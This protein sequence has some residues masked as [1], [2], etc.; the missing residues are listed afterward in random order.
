M[1]V[2]IIRQT[3]HKREGA[4]LAAFIKELRADV[5]PEGVAGVPHVAGW[6]PPH[7]RSLRAAAERMRSRP[8]V[9]YL[10]CGECVAC[11]DAGGGRVRCSD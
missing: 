1:D 10:R 5:N 4:E 8:V 11:K 6:I 7:R 9:Q 2:A 3:D